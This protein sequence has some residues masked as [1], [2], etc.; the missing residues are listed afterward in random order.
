M[1]LPIWLKELLVGSQSKPL[2]YALSF[3]EDPIVR[4][5]IIMP[6]TVYFLWLIFIGIVTGTKYGKTISKPNYILGLLGIL[7]SA[8]VLGGY[9]LLLYFLQTGGN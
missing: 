8:L 1:N 7:F 9:L 3:F 6:I 4:V 2:D 5:L